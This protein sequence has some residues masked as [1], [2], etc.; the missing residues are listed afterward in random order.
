MRASRVMSWIPR[1]WGWD[2]RACPYGQGDGQGD[3]DADSLTFAGTRV[4]PARQ[5]AFAPPLFDRLRPTGGASRVTPL[6]VGQVRY[7]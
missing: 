7:S 1:V 3:D 4:E 5:V 6:P 2:L